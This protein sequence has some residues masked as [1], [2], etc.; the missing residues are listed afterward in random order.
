MLTSRLQSCH[1]LSSALQMSSPLLLAKLNQLHVNKEQDG[2]QDDISVHTPH[3]VDGLVQQLQRRLLGR[4]GM[5]QRPRDF[6]SILRCCDARRVRHVNRR[7]RNKG[8]KY[9]RMVLG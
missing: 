3:I 6:I 1:D 7:H 4:Q 2:R 8:M 5:Y 9:Q